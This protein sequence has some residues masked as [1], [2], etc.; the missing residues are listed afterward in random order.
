MTGAGKTFFELASPLVLGMASLPQRFEEETS[1]HEV[2]LAVA[3]TPRIVAEDLPECVKA[4]CGQ[5]PRVRLSLQEVGDEQV[6]DLV[7]SGEVDLGLTGGRATVAAGPWAH[8]PWLTSE[9]VYELDVVL[10]T[11]REHPLA[12]R[13]PVRPEDLR[14]YPLV[15][16]V[17]A[18]PDPAVMAVLDK[19]D[20]LVDHQHQ[21]KSIFCGNYIP[22]R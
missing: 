17:D 19:A 7:S 18:F 4:F 16:A 21:I 2:R 8:G 3:S 14:G 1:T 13:R 11:P 9:P 5:H 22:I 20:V 15:N 12:R 10:I 6:S